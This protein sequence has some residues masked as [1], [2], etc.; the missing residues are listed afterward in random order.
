MKVTL[1]EQEMS[2]ILQL[3]ENK[4]F[5]NKFKINKINYNIN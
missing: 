1:Q 5:K 4:T 2:L 3:E